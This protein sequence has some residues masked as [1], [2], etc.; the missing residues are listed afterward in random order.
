MGSRSSWGGALRRSHR[1]ELQRLL[2]KRAPA[3]LWPA[4]S[5]LRCDLSIQFNDS[6]Q[7]GG[8]LSL[9]PEMACFGPTA[10]FVKP[11]RS[12][13]RLRLYLP[14]NANWRGGIRRRYAPHRTL[15][16]AILVSKNLWRKLLTRMAWSSA[17]WQF[18]KAP[19]SL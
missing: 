8:R 16:G 15:P 12:R 3:R 19:T 11:L 14:Y 4:Q 7:C 10:E 9:Q 6:G 1:T 5:H 2:G 17:T 13:H 18:S